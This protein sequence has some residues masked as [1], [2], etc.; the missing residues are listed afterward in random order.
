MAKCWMSLLPKQILQRA[1]LFWASGG[2]LVYTTVSICCMRKPQLK[3]S[4]LR[5]SMNVS[6][7]QWG[8]L[9]LEWLL[10]YQLICFQ[11]LRSHMLTLELFY[12]KSKKWNIHFGYILLLLGWMNIEK[13]WGFL[14]I[15]VLLKPSLASE[16]YLCKFIKDT[17]TQELLHN[18]FQSG[19]EDIL[20]YIAFTRAK[21]QQLKRKR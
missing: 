10:L 18:N 19:H 20:C 8:F 15:F 13:D 4:S 17:Q 12:F 16:L 5:D 1:E 2:D 14:V 21:R 6:A 7:D 9:K 11:I 3:A